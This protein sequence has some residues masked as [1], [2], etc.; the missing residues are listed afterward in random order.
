MQINT[1]VVPQVT[2]Q[3][4][5]IAMQETPVENQSFTQKY[6]TS[7]QDSIEEEKTPILSTSMTMDERIKAIAQ[8]S[9][10]IL[11]K[12]EKTKPKPKK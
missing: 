1:E 6:H 4:E 12:R 2:D 9:E 8:N 3:V 10:S 11:A 5:D 7:Q